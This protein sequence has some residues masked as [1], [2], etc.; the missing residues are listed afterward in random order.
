MKFLNF[1]SSVFWDITRL[2]KQPICLQLLEAAQNGT[3]GSRLPDHAAVLLP[4]RV[5]IID[6]YRSSLTTRRILDQSFA[7]LSQAVLDLPEDGNSSDSGSGD[8]KKKK[9]KGDHESNNKIT[10]TIERE[11]REVQ[12]AISMAYSLFGLTGILQANQTPLLYHFLI[13]QILPLRIIAS[14]FSSLKSKV[15]SPKVGVPNVDQIFQ[16]LLTPFPSLRYLIVTGSCEGLLP[17][18]SSTNSP[19][20][21]SCDS[22]PTQSLAILRNQQ[23]IADAGARAIVRLKSTRC[24]CV[25]NGE[26]VDLPE[27]F[28]KERLNARSAALHL[29]KGNHVV[30]VAE[31]AFKRS[32]GLS[33]A[34]A[35]RQ[36]T[37]DLVKKRDSNGTVLDVPLQALYFYHLVGATTNMDT[38][39][40]MMKIYHTRFTQRHPDLLKRALKS[41]QNQQRIANAMG[42][43]YCLSPIIQFQVQ[44]HSGHVVEHGSLL[45]KNG[46]IV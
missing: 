17:L 37:H 44:N 27:H 10:T 21:A 15:V 39:A 22:P 16:Q 2:R 24:I 4:A 6:L 11:L 5:G 42:Y 34:I 12:K 32:S 25:V 33:T 30:A 9:K 31:T 18:V 45:V 3:S 1:V 19:I 46:S 26:D 8:G 40:S 23:L 38:A 43:I 41:L 28:K 13:S 35:E 20:S 7:A 14:H 29:Q 36:K